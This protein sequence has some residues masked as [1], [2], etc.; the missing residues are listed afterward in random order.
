MKKKIFYKQIRMEKDQFVN[1]LGL[2]PSATLKYVT[3]IDINRM[4]LAKS[5]KLYLGHIKYQDIITKIY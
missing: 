1:R 3:N 2:D 5:I 4:M